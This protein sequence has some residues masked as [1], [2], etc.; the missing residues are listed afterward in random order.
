MSKIYQIQLQPVEGGWM[1]RDE[2]TGV[3]D[4]TEF[5]PPGQAAV[6]MKEQTCTMSVVVMGPDILYS[7]TPQHQARCQ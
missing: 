6:A 7:V 1:S 3:P 4:A 2:S 5:V